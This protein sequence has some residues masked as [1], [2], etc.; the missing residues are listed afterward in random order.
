VGIIQKWTQQ[1]RASVPTVPKHIVTGAA[2]AAGAGLVALASLGFTT[3]LDAMSNEKLVGILSQPNEP[4][5]VNVAAAQAKSGGA[6]TQKVSA[7]RLNLETGKNFEIEKWTISRSG[8]AIRSPITN[9]DN[10]GHGNVAGYQKPVDGATR[11]NT[12]FV[13][14]DG[15]TV[16]KG[17]YS[18]ER[19]PN[20]EWWRGTHSY[21]DCDVAATFKCSYVLGADAV[22]KRM[23]VDPWLLKGCTLETL[24]SNA[25]RQADDGSSRQAAVSDA[26]KAN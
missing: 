5:Q 10:V 13:G 9:E 8:H 23:S 24:P 25:G 22:R 19:G 15:A 16:G 17:Y 12:I 11:Y 4:G 20:D 3:A 2:G 14:F 7:S 26:A 1:L 6:C 18:L 21:Y